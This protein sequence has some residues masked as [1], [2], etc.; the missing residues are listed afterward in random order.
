MKTPRFVLARLLACALPLPFVSA[1]EGTIFVPANAETSLP[2]FHQPVPTQP[3]LPVEL[4]SEFLTLLAAAGPEGAEGPIPSGAPREFSIRVSPPEEGQTEAAVH[5]HRDGEEIVRRVN[6]GN[7]R[8]VLVG[9]GKMLTERLP[10]P[11]GL[12]IAGV[13]ALPAM[14]TTPP[15]PTTW[16]GVATD[17]APEEVRAQ[18]PPLAAGTGVLVRSVVPDSPAFKAGLQRYDI[19]AKLDDQLLVNPAQLRALVSGKKEQDTIKLTVF[20]KGIDLVLDVKLG[21]RLGGDDPWS[22]SS[23]VT[24]TPSV[25]GAYMDPLIF[26]TRA[27]VVDSKG[28][29]ITATTDGSPA[30]VELERVQEALKKAGVGADVI[31][32]VEKNLVDVRKQLE[33]SKTDLERNKSETLKRLEES[34]EDLAKA[35]ENARAAAEKARKEAVERL[36]DDASKSPVQEIKP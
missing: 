11:H 13:P 7:A 12:A 5:I 20:R 27:L 32:S 30:P 25:A 8:K 36:H 31:K 2:L 21:I 3:T 15:V 6:V 33:K 19:L 29:V 16:L 24:N 17:E 14:P 28:N 35:L 9:G 34:A 18:L 10:G 4:E 22:V 1:Q 26:Q 23:F